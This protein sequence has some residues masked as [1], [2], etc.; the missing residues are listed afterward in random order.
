MAIVASNDIQ[1]EPFRPVSLPT[2]RELGAVLIRQRWVVLATAVVVA[3]TMWL[4]GQWRPMYVAQMKILV[5]RQR[6]DAVISPEATS[7]VMWG[8][9]QVSEEDLN[10][11]VELLKSTDL[12]RK[13]VSATGLDHD[14]SVRHQRTPERAMDAAVLQLEKHL[15]VEAIRKTNIISVKYES[16]NA[17]V[18]RNVL[19][20]LSQ[21]YSEK[22]MEVHR[23]SGEV[24]FFNQQVALYKQNLADAQQRLMAFDQ[25]NGVV[26]P[27]ME[28]DLAVQRVNDFS[29][30]ARQASQ[31]LQEGNERLSVL[32]TE[33]AHMQ[34]QTVA[35]E[36]TSSNEQLLGQM[37]QTLSTLELKRTEMLGRY[38]PTYR[39][40]QDIEAQITELKGSIAREMNSPQH[41]ETKQAN[42]VYQ[43]A[44][45]ELAKTEA[46]VAMMKTRATAATSISAQ[47]QGKAEGLDQQ[48]VIQQDLLRDEKTQEENYLLY[49]RKLEEARSSEAL[50][51][52][53]IMN[54]V[55]A[56]HPV[57]PTLPA[58]TPPYVALMTLLLCVTCGASSAFV[59]DR[60]APSFRTADEVVRYLN[61][62]VLASLPKA[63]HYQLTD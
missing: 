9:D 51:R 25:Q 33:M 22:H 57:T 48:S 12:L 23:P 58:R 41:D 49:Q 38:T 8:G 53:G 50:D 36:R 32:R 21:A 24:Q 34:P 39:P 61:L 44:Q 47:Y 52:G 40:I 27:G 14:P 29:A 62:P 31:A 18:A 20:A 7:P 6:V 30:T 46:D 59:A 54:V 37:K 56:Q 15:K 55:I 4:T 26:S 42:P 13:V 5:V 43:W 3:I 19:V 35:A 17:Q 11:E 63:E 2:P 28:R 10:S 16:P 45:Q 1:I 60:M